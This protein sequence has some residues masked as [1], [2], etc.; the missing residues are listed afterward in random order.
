MISLDP[1]A[2]FR[3][4]WYAGRLLAET[5]NELVILETEVYHTVPGDLCEPGVYRTEIIK[6]LI[7][8]MMLGSCH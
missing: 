6:N 5:K 8:P 4:R 1:L 2:E 7:M 3:I